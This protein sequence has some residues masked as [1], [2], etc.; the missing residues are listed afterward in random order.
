MRKWK[1]ILGG[2][3]Y[4]TL[5]GFLTVVFIK[6]GSAVFFRK[7]PL[8]NEQVE[9]GQTVL[10]VDL[11]L[12]SKIYDIDSLIVRE[13]SK[14]LA[15]VNENDLDPKNPGV[16]SAQLLDD[17]SFQ[18][19][20]IPESGSTE[21]WQE[22]NFQILIR[23]S[24]LTS[25]WITF[26]FIFLLSGLVLFIVSL[27]IDSKGR[28][29]IRDCITS[30]Q[31][32]ADE[33]LRFGQVHQKRI[34]LYKHVITSVIGFSF[35]YVFLEWIF[36]ITKPSFMDLVSGW[37][38]L[39]IFLLSGLL[40]ALLF[41]IITT[42]IFILDVFFRYVSVPL[43]KSLLHLSVALL[44]VIQAMILLDN[45]TYTVFKLGIVSSNSIVRG[46]YAIIFTIG[47]II[48]VRNL[49]K[50]YLQKGSGK[51]APDWKLI[52]AFSLI[53]VSII[54]G[55]VKLNRIESSVN[56]G[57]SNS[58]VRTPNIILLSNDGLDVSHMSVYG[59]ERITT[60]FMDSIAESSLI[61]MNNYANA[62][63]STGSDTA[64]LTGKLPFETRVLYP[65][66]TLQGMDM[67]EHLPGILQDYGYKTLSFGVPHYVDVNVINFQR[68]FDM[69]NCVDNHQ[70]RIMN[71]SI[72]YGFGDSLY[73]FNTVLNRIAD[74]ILHIFFVKDMV[75]P[76]DFVVD[77]FESAQHVSEDEIFDC[78][79]EQLLLTSN[80][81]RPLF[82]H[83]H[84]VSTHGP[85]FYPEVRKFSEGA[86]QNNDWMV[87]FYDDAILNYDISVED[88]V[89]YLRDIGQ[90][91]NTILV[92]FTDHAS[93]W[94][95]VQ[96]IP[97][98]IHFPNSINSGIITQNTQ[99]LDIAPTILDYMNLG[100]PDWMRG[101]SLINE[102]ERGRLIIS[103]DVNASFID[104]DAE[105]ININVIKPPF[106][107]F[108]FMYV[109][110]CQNVSM[111]DLQSLEITRNQMSHY[112]DPC[113]DEEL[114]SEQEIWEAAGQLLLDFGYE[115][116]ADW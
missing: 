26:G 37:D 88:L 14:V 107:Q 94:R 95:A 18:V 92:L 38:K 4:L 3:I 58:E 41:C 79:K 61:M 96:K 89:E 77:S 109:I 90:Y 24:F 1:C 80:E 64:L 62:N 70:S 52:I 81:G 98:I 113:P 43:H 67:Y 5:L 19:K 49:S 76:Y 87:D 99:N 13:R 9:V 8:A 23:P 47:L 17:N 105:R 34:A 31:Q 93:K 100:Q 54:A 40:F 65:P 42:C 112:E 30:E 51:I 44:L 60:P 85:K 50:S 108:G 55:F 97:L 29:V 25:D 114:L 46:L 74:R 104:P 48:T 53:G 28:G 82:A 86:Q 84:L 106:Y 10:V 71:L 33:P 56:T 83:I 66:N 63:T 75:N 116:P 111:I 110:Q 73:F 6:P 11:K 72:Q 2:F 103:A 68:A 21:G 20:V 15:Q 69:V 102:I 12:S 57:I 45:F 36:F 59:Y 35:L 32:T 27:I 78:L 101:N 91:D 16:Y 115:L 7:I 22:G 39:A